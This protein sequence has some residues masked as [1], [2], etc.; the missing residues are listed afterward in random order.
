MNQKKFAII[1]IDVQGNLAQSMYKKEDLFKNLK[2]L[3][4]GAKLLDIPLL[5]TEQ[6]PEK[7]GP[8]LPEISA[9]IPDKSPIV[10]TVF[11]CARDE[12]FISQLESLKV[13]HVALCGIE[14]HVCVYQTALDLIEM[15]YHVDI[16][17]DA[18]S[19]RKGSNKKIGIDRIM[20]AGGTITSVET[21]LFE[22]QEVATGNVFRKLI[23]LVK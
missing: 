16:I 22:V 10:K 14:T 20:L 9:L 1:L 21:L 7:L 4:E 15:G 17:S 5:L 19:S 12:N 23:K 2:I 13:D 3:I 18:V 6:V 11:S 8:T